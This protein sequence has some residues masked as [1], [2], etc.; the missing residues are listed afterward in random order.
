M[1]EGEST[2]RIVFVRNGE[3]NPESGGVNGLDYLLTN[4]GHQRAAYFGSYLLDILYAGNKPDERLAAILAFGE[5]QQRAVAGDEDKHDALTRFDFVRPDL[6]DLPLIRLV[7]D[8]TARSRET[9]TVAV[10]IAGLQG[11]LQEKRV[12]ESD[13]DISPARLREKFLRW[14]EKPQQDKAAAERLLRKFD[15]GSRGVQ[16]LGRLCV[17]A[18]ASHKTIASLVAPFLGIDD[19]MIGSEH[20]MDGRL[21]DSNPLIPFGSVTELEHSP[22]TGLTLV[23]AGIDPHDAAVWAT[24][25]QR[26]PPGRRPQYGPPLDIS[27]YVA[28]RAWSP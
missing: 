13:G 23:H 17:V 26:T 8:G 21:T 3:S 19:D 25:T 22:A 16:S 27:E 4:Q 15:S 7:H 1:A 14:I 20:P 24:S 6:G 12:L 5:M 10:G 9:L 18:A 28:K 2:T 11:R